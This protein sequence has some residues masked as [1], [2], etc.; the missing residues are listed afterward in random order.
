M[1]SVGFMRNNI[2]SR[3]ITYIDQRILITIQSM[4]CIVIYTRAH[5]VSFNWSSAFIALSNNEDKRFWFS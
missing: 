2:Y 4:L 1:K 5:P 3:I